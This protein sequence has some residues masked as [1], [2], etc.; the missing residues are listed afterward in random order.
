MSMHN[1]KLENRNQKLFMKNKN[2]EH[3]S[4]NKIGFVAGVVVP[5]PQGRRHRWCAGFHTGGRCKS[6][7]DN[8][9]II[10][11][12]IYFLDAHGVSVQTGARAQ[13]QAGQRDREARRA[14]AR[15]AGEEVPV[16][17]AQS[18]WRRERRH[19]RPVVTQPCD[20]NPF[21]NCFY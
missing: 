17:R 18:S 2:A 8:A 21:Q 9:G 5:I 11:L 4:A 14:S 12:K 19:E 13:S 16:R 7:E 15:R 10:N 1:S 3:V 20:A 6:A